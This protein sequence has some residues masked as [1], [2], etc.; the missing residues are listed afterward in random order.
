MNQ[1]QFIKSPMNIGKLPFRFHLAHATHILHGI[2]CRVTL[3]QAQIA[4]RSMKYHRSLIHT[5][6][7][8]QQFLFSLF[9]IKLHLFGVMHFRFQCPCSLLLYNSGSEVKHKFTEFK[10]SLFKRLSLLHN[11]CVTR[12]IIVATVAIQLSG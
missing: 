6:Q 2:K 9:G 3:R 4:F 8:L 12:H 1:W 5:P 11:R 10:L 7:I